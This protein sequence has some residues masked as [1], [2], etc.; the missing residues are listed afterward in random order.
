MKKILFAAF[1]FG[2]PTMG[3]ANAASASPL[4][5]SAAISVCD[6]PNL[7]NAAS[8]RTVTIE[9]ALFWTAHQDLYLV[10]SKCDDKMVR[11]R[12][13]PPYSTGSKIGEMDYLLY[14]ASAKSSGK[15]VYCICTGALTHNSSGLDYLNLE[16]VERVW[17]SKT[18]PASMRPSR[19]SRA[20]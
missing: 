12:T 13:N 8:A 19:N 20:K 14:G 6:V 2:I 17:A 16:R 18:P 10:D 9:G 3:V 5:S 1:V 11:L 4:Q 7:T 15:V